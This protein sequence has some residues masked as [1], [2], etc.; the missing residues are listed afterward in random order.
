MKVTAISISVSGSSVQMF[1]VYAP[2]DGVGVEPDESAPVPDAVVALLDLA[3]R[4]MGLYAGSSVFGD[5]LA[6]SG[7]RAV[8]EAHSGGR[9]L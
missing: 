4:L 7:G 6:V 1:N 2:D 3:W 8:V 5:A 9:R